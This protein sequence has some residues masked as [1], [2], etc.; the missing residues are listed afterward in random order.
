MKALALASVRIV[1]DDG[2]L[3]RCRSCGHVLAIRTPG[4][5]RIRLLYGCELDERGRPDLNCPVCGDRMRIA[6][7]QIDAAL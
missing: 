2:R 7:E 3:V 6:R 4:G 5:K 1:P